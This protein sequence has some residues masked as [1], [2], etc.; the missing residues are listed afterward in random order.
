MALVVLVAVAIIVFAFRTI[1]APQ[2]VC[3]LDVQSVQIRLLEASGGSW[4]LLDALGVF[5]CALLRVAAR[6]PPADRSTTRCRRSVLR[7]GD[8]EAKCL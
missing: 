5:C 2:Y 1:L 8:D 6:T 7:D 3:N 4:R